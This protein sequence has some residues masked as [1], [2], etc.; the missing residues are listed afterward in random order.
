MMFEDGD[1]DEARLRLE[2]PELSADELVRIATEHPELRS[3]V[4]MHPNCPSGLLVQIL[5]EVPG[6]PAPTSE[7]P[8]T[9]ALDASDDAD[10]TQW[11]VPPVPPASASPLPDST[12][13]ESEIQE[14]GA[15]GGGPL[16]VPILPPVSAEGAAEEASAA[17]R[18]SGQPQ[19]YAPGQPFDYE[20]DDDQP[21]RRGGAALAIVLVAVIAIVAVVFAGKFLLGGGTQRTAPDAAAEAPGSSSTEDA[22]EDAGESS[23]DEGDQRGE[24]KPKE[25]LPSEAYQGARGPAPSGSL[26]P[27]ETVSKSGLKIASIATPTGNIGCDIRLTDSSEDPDDHSRDSIICAVKSWKDDAPVAADPQPDK[28][29]TPYVYLG[30][31]NKEPSYGGSHKGKFCFEKDGCEDGFKGQKLEYDKAVTYGDFV[32]VSEMHG[33]TCWNTKTERG[34]FL[35][36]DH[37]LTF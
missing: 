34:V 30:S 12:S 35:S 25:P 8:A 21:R 22:E 37:F 4:F 3:K 14:P 17:S 6:P 1:M 2:D 29:T 10:A 15:S 31:E 32:C 13:E 7:S 16:F 5:S 23:E 18:H 36:R 11:S 33:L 27:S 20:E 28:G 19:P 26:E 24:D 9:D